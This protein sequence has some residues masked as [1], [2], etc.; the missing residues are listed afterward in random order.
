MQLIE[1]DKTAEGT[2]QQKVDTFSKSGQ[3]I[4]TREQGKERHE[5]G[6]IGDKDRAHRVETGG[7]HTFHTQLSEWTLVM[8]TR[9]QKEGERQKEGG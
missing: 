1:F 3:R 6:G 8:L 5:N 9:G 2:C 4:K 7:Q